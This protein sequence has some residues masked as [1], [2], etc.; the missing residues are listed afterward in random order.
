MIR[1]FLFF[2]LLLPASGAFGWGLDAHKTVTD[3]AVRL[4]PTRLQEFY[5]ENRETLRELSIDA[6]RRKDGDRSEGPK[7]YIDL[8]LYP[9]GPLPVLRKDA[10]RKFGMDHL[11]A[12]GWAVWNT[13]KVYDDLVAALRRRDYESILRL[14]G[15]LSHYVSDLHV[16]LHTTVNFNGQFTDDTG[17]HAR[18]ES[19]LVEQFPEQLAFNPKPAERIPD[20][21]KW[22]HQIAEASHR[23]FKGVL[24]GDRKNAYADRAD[25]YS[26]ARAVATHAPM[27]RGR[28]ND[29]AA[30][31]SS[32]W[33][34][35]WI[36]AGRPVL[37]RIDFSGLISTPKSIESGEAVFYEGRYLTPPPET[38][39]ED[40]RRMLLQIE[41]HLRTKSSVRLADVTWEGADRHTTRF[42]IDVRE[43]A[44]GDDLQTIQTE[45]QK[46][47]KTMSVR[48]RRQD[49]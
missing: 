31:I 43:G 19:R 41:H 33:Y 11:R 38:W 30:A 1:C 15:D 9:E 25:G 3:R 8:E 49:R 7:H 13:Q 26:M 32:V 44:A 12:S 36:D 28:M 42:R 17:V 21:P 14:S 18:F 48:V 45:L 22:L 34:T 35:A 2:L 10:I 16:P 47:L 20:V 24:E 6:D 27:A 29:A 46:L 5:W 23:L 39:P 4:L 40:I 37:P